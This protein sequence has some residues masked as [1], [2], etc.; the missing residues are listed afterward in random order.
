MAQ[1][2]NENHTNGGLSGV[3]RGFGRGLMKSSLLERTNNTARLATNS[4]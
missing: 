3:V 2:G 4:R 1:G